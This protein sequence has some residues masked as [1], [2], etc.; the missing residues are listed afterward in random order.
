MSEPREPAPPMSAAFATRVQHVARML[1]VGVPVVVLVG[2][3]RVLQLWRHQEH[4]RAVVLLFS[5][6]VVLLGVGGFLPWFLQR[7]VERRGVL[8]EEE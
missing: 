3:L 5:L 7:T 6:L 8:D 1:R 2:L 4:Q